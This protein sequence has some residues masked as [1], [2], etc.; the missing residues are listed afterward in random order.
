[1]SDTSFITNQTIKKLGVSGINVN[2]SLSTLS[3]SNEIVSS[4]KVSGIQVRGYNNKNF[5]SLPACLPSDN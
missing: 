5:V 2:L 4:T 3:S 1:M